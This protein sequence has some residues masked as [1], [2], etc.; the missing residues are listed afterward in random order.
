M[1][2]DPRPGST[3]GFPI[4]GGRFLRGACRSA[5][6]AFVVVDVNG[7]NDRDGGTMRYLLLI[8]VSG[9]AAALSIVDGVAAA[10]RRARSLAGTSAERVFLDTRLAECLENQ[11]R[12]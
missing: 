9:P 5:P 6:P 10:Y 8:E 2:S 1:L 11:L 3:T 12:P 7:H 4:S